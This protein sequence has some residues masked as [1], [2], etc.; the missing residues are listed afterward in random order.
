M[1]LCSQDGEDA[2][3]VG[4]SVGVC[5]SGAKCGAQTDACKHKESFLSEEA[6][7]C[8][9]WRNSGGC[10][11]DGPREPDLDKD[12]AK[13]GAPQQLQVLGKSSGFCECSDGGMV[14]L[15][16]D[17]GRK[18][19]FCENL[20]AQSAF[21]GASVVLSRCDKVPA[22]MSLSTCGVNAGAIRYSLHPDN[23]PDLPDSEVS[24][25]AY[26]SEYTEPIQVDVSQVLFVKTCVEYPGLKRPVIQVHS[27]TRECNDE[28]LTQ[29]LIREWGFRDSMAFRSR[30]FPRSGFREHQYISHF[31]HDLPLDAEACFGGMQMLDLTTPSSPERGPWRK[32]FY[33]AHEDKDCEHVSFGNCLTGKQKWRMLLNPRLWILYTD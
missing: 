22:Q 14:E 13:P 12:C 3:A 29:N 26:P 8:T 5:K 10:R 21:S 15:D 32:C 6:V 9:K 7:H 11:A 25:A 20:C 4:V 31:P 19:L 17:F 24:C 1:L 23:E 33:A 2:D 16:C 28:P 27:I 18:P 30:Q